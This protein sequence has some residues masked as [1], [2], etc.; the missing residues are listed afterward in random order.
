M[1]YKEHEDKGTNRV[2][3]EE[4]QIP[5][6]LVVDDK[7]ASNFAL[8]KVLSMLNAE[9][10]T[11]ESGIHALEILR[12]RDITLV[13]SDVYMPN[14][15]GYKMVE[16]MRSDPKTAKTPVIF[17]TGIHA[18]DDVVH[19]AYRLGAVDFL[20]KPVDTKMLL[21]KINL[22]LRFHN[23]I[24]SLEN[25]IY[26][27][28]RFM[29][30]YK[31]NPVELYQNLNIIDKNNATL[32]VTTH[33]PEKPKILV[34]DDREAN[35]YAMK[36]VLKKLPV[37]VVLADNAQSALEHL[38][39][40]EYAVALLDVEM[41]AVDGFQLADKI[42]EL[43]LKYALPIVFV[44]A[45]NTG[46]DDVYKGYDSGAIDYLTKPVDPEVLVAKV[47]LFVDL[48]AHRMEL[49]HILNEKDGVLY[50]L[51]K[52]NIKLG[53]L[54]SHDPL[55]MCFNRTGFEDRLEKR[56]NAAKR[57]KRIFALLFLDLNHFK[58]V[59]D[60]Y[61]HECGDKLLQAVA[62]RLK[63]CLRESDYICRIGGD[64]FAVI[65][66]EI[67][68]QYDAGNIA[69]TI[70][71][72]VDKP[73][74]IDEHEFKIGASIGISCYP[75][76]SDDLTVTAS[77][78]SRNA[79]IAMY[80]AKARRTNTFEYYTKEYSEQHHIRLMLETNLKFALE[81]SE[82]FIEYQPKIDMRTG[83]VIGV[84]ALIRWNHPEHGVVNPDTFIPIA[85][86]TQ[87]IIPIGNWVVDTVAAQ[88]E[89][90][91]NEHN[92]DVHV[93]INV[94]PYQLSDP[95]FVSNMKDIANR[96]SVAPSS[97]EIELT[98]TALMDKVKLSDKVLSDLVDMGFELSVDD[99]GK[100]YSMLSYLKRLPLKAIKIDQEFIQ[101]IT[102][103]DGSAVIAKTIIALANNFKLRLIAEGV[104]T[105]EQRDL[106]LDIGCSYA[107]GFFY[108]HPLSPEKVLQYIKE[109]R[110]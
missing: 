60:I 84:E 106:L 87:M 108:S 19:E 15:D 95:G 41:P 91:K 59:N 43:N 33:S 92:V 72:Q 32:T 62:Q 14:I 66:D 56:L 97:I 55:T 25:T 75:G 7:S 90:W 1:K 23:Q 54:A 85:E 37:D 2:E 104:E 5:K 52:Q 82:F 18:T 21:A 98:E 80:R 49:E 3:I 101:D 22:F 24:K 76:P 16:L 51:K 40:D 79:D 44:T 71:Q 81:R 78:L 53:F 34:V 29:E 86:E 45:H 47:S 6:L 88:I 110:Q 4:Q 30:F 39:H 65:L 99:F 35:L 31:N 38:K 9:I 8:T 89:K 50:Q 83:N 61:G 12:K 26:H 70:L 13:I 96:Y 105:Q 10:I 100:G 67:S 73:F 28:R 17:V 48:H 109:H 11:A 77:T 69:T 27:Y 102:E 46:I 94:S 58:S 63:D 36:T 68:E 20:Y 103:N 57:Y 74:I 93:A 107:Q 42:Q 64:E